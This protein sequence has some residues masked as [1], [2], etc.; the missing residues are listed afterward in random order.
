MQTVR[1][2]ASESVAALRPD[3]SGYSDPAEMSGDPWIQRAGVEARGNRPRERSYD[4]LGL[5]NLFMSEKAL[6]I[7]RNMGIE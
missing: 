7:E 3:S 5:R 6:D 4:P 2:A 1:D